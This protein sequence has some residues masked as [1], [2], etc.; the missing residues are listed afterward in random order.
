MQAYKGYFI[1]ASA[2][3]MHP[4]NPDWYVGG[5]MFVSGRSSSIVEVTRFSFGGS[6]PIPQP[7]NST[8]YLAPYNPTWPS[9]FNRLTKHIHE[10][11]A[12]AILLL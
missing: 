3:P 1:S 9:L 6:P 7:L 11:L 10:V 8:I 4:F 5:K 2:M 12:G